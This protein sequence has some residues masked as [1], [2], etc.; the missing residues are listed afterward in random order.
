ME[1]QIQIADH[2]LT[3]ET[4]PGPTD[5]IFL[6]LNGWTSMRFFWTPILPFFQKF[7]TC[8]T[9]DLPG[10]FPAVAPKS[11]KSFSPEQIVD[12]QLE[13]IQSI[14]PQKSR[15]TLV[16]H[17]TGG[18]VAIALLLRNLDFVNEC[19][20]ISPVV[21]GPV[22]GPLWPIKMA[23]EHNLGGLMSTTI[24]L[25]SQIPNAMEIFFR[26]GI[27]NIDSFLKEPQNKEYLS[28]YQELFQ[29]MDF[30][31]MGEY[32]LMLDRS[33]LRPYLPKVST[34]T[35]FLHGKEDKIVPIRQSIEAQGLIPNSK[36]QIFEHS[37]HIP[38][39]EEREKAEKILEDFL[40]TSEN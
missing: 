37:G 32:L 36:I 15:I 6:L 21:H 20:L 9:L 26:L 3:Y 24:G 14:L 5:R 18:F 16:G 19:I 28:K 33:D 2:T 29:K 12:I 30:E 25:F 1:K 4:F 40:R 39:F 11:F 10:H 27:H 34:P 8:I 22:K 13:F 7:G 35:L 23:Y 31:T 17:S 38:I